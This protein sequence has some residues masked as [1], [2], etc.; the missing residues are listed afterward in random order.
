MELHSS[1]FFDLDVQEEQMWFQS[2]PKNPKCGR[3]AQ[4]I[5][6]RRFLAFPPSVLSAA[7]VRSMA[8]C[9]CRLADHQHAIPCG[10][11][12]RLGNRG[13]EG[14]GAWEPHHIVPESNGGRGKVEKEAI[15]GWCRSRRTTSYFINVTSS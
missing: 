15:T 5:S 6:R 9:E 2:W 7:W 1:E 4:R 3:F 11:S 13:K 14:E 12:L 8:A 10:A